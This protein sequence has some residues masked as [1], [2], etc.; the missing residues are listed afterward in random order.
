MGFDPRSSTIRLQFEDLKNKLMIAFCLCLVLLFKFWSTLTRHRSAT[1]NQIHSNQIHSNQ[2]HSNQIR[3]LT[4][5]CFMRSWGI[6]DDYTTFDYKNERL[7]ELIKSEFP[8]YDILCLQE[9]F[10]TFSFRSHHLVS[11]AGFKY[12][13]VPNDPPLWSRKFMDS[14]LIILSRYPIEE[15]E[16]VSF[17]H[18]GVYSDQFADKGFQYA[19]IQDLHIINTHVQS[20][21]QVNDTLA[22]SVKLHQWSQIKQFM[23]H[24]NKKTWLVCGDLN[25]NAY[26]DNNALYTK[27]LTI[28]KMNDLLCPQDPCHRPV[29]ARSHDSVTNPGKEPR[30]VD[31][32]LTSL[33]CDGS[34]SHV[35][36]PASHDFVTTKDTACDSNA[37]HNYVIIQDRTFKVIACRVEEFCLSD[38]YGISAFIRNEC[39]ERML[40]H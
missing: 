35:F 9:V 12:Y 23:D 3:I 2:I 14:G 37:S 15:F 28:F 34:T 29:T 13:I 26:E 5:N 30:S 10:A 17:T 21:Y 4:L 11:R 22:T 7:E 33:P 25:C 40:C 24:K 27:M 39:K 20:D 32:I 6:A 36:Y 16:C 18:T 1:P 38:H 19:K 8:K 31:Y